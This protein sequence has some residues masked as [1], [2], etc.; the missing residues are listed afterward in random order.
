MDL[1]DI[2]DSLKSERR[3]LEASQGLADPLED[4]ITWTEADK[5]PCIMLPLSKYEAHWLYWRLKVHL[6]SYE[7]MEWSEMKEVLEC[8]VKRISSL[9]TLTTS[10]TAECSTP[11]TEPSE[12]PGTPEETSLLSDV[13]DATHL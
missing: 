13:E 3:P 6:R 5:Q 4:T 12:P 8:L 9:S 7:A 1:G 10:C 2:L 11:V